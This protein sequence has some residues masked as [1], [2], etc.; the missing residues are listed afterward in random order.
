ME[1][2]SGGIHFG[3]ICVF[4]SVKKNKKNKHT[5]F[6]CVCVEEDNAGPCV[7]KTGTS[8]HANIWHVLRNE[9][10]P[11]EI[12]IYLKCNFT[13]CKDFRGIYVLTLC[14]LEHFG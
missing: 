12:F 7:N 1:D 2:S 13:K 4:E 8:T 9:T 6:V 10:Q 5:L 11:L 14:K 3:I